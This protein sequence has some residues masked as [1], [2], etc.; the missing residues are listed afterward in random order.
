MTLRE[1]IANHMGPSPPSAS[2]RDTFYHFGCALRTPT[3][4]PY[5]MV[6]NPLPHAATGPRARDNNHSEWSELFAQYTQ[7]QLIPPD[8]DVAL[9]FGLGVRKTPD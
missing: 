6:A 3:Q 4:S 9:S 2:G 1:Y 8:A 7:P 5:G